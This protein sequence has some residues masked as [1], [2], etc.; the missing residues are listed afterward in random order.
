M[1]EN[2]L[3]R[4]IRWLFIIAFP[5]VVASFAVVSRVHG[6]DRQDTF[7]ILAISIVWSVLIVGCALLAGIFKRASALRD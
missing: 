7:E 3:E 5:A 2:R 1:G 6:T 4:V